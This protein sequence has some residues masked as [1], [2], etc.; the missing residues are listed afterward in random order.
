MLESQLRPKQQKRPKAQ[1]LWWQN[2]RL[3]L[4]IVLV[5]S[6]GLLTLRSP[7]NHWFFKSLEQQR[8]NDRSSPLL[9]LRSLTPKARATQLR[10]IATGTTSSFNNQKI[11]LLDRYRARYL[12]A[13]D[14]LQQRQGKLAL[15][16]LQGLS[17]DYPLLRPQIL[18]KTAQAYQQNNQEKASQETLNY[19][20]KTYPDSPLA[21]NALSLLNG[22]DSESEARLI[23][24]YP[25]HP[26]TQEIARQRLS[27]N[28]DQFELLLLLAKYSRESDLNLI[29]DRLVLEY[30]GNL[31]PEDWE[32]IADGYWREEEHRK[33]ADAYT[34]AS[35]TPRNLYRAAR[36]FHR[37]GNIDTARR[38][39]QRLLNE[40]HDAREAGQV[41]IYLASISSGDEAVVYLEK[42][43]SKFPEVAPEAYLSKAIVHERFN[44]QQAA[45]RAR[46]KLL[47]QY[48]NSPTN[49]E[50]RWKT[51]QTLATNGNKE[52]AWQWMQPVVKSNLEFDAAPKALYWTGKWATE[53]DKLD[54]AQTAFKKVITL[55]PQS[56]WAWR[57]AVKLDWDVG[58]F[59][60]LRPL[61]PA[62]DLAETYSPL[63]ISSEA[64]QEL[65]LLGQ[66]QDA[67]L[68]LQ[69]EIEQHH[70]LSVNEQFSEGI[71]K[72]KLG[73]FSE[74]MQQIWDLTKRENPQE[75]QQWRALR[76][77]NTYWHGLF[78]FPYQDKILRYAK[79]DQINPLLVISVMRKESTFN[80]EIDSVVG[81]VGLMQIVPP[82]AEWVA[83]QI[84]LPKYSLTNP[85]DNIKIGTWYLAHNHNRYRNS[86]L[87]AVASY[88]AGTGNVNQWLERYDVD[89]PDRFVEQIPFA[90]TKDYVEGVFGNYWNYLRLYNPEI[91]QKVN[92]L[93]RKG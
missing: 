67:W 46:Q 34:L 12:L 43:I 81:A 65:Y 42:A 83:E 88:N 91:R 89:S 75:K 35:P 31:T 24:E 27:K 84:D 72:L 40:Y 16:Y 13:S 58:N 9:R 76:Q 6:L 45:D 11:T 78:P 57:A 85:E 39:Y 18:F 28:P 86:S 26:L 60:Q 82:T 90:E 29:R 8:Q 41:L 1:T 68:V 15:E 52:D 79:Q 51:A 20:I 44:K 59:N 74:G 73:K 66:Y 19:L 4:L 36:G 47:N 54:A 69:S 17:R 21:A 87:L 64:L 49:A 61:T 80:P 50:Y 22:N 25:Y 70:Q 38:A 7:K 37:N 2:K 14:L 63:P 77:T 71:L 92:S 62:I 33:A 53:L 32:A 10:A 48:R 55:Y 30:P 3:I 56:Y 5:S 93:T 23:E